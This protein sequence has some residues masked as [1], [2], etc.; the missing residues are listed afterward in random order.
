MRTSRQS[1]FIVRI[2]SFFTSLTSSKVFFFITILGIVVYANGAFNHFI[3]D[4][5]TQIT[6]NTVVQSASN[7]IHFF[8]G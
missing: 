4:D 7:I 8:S 3:G 5:N 6:Q 1:N 2:R